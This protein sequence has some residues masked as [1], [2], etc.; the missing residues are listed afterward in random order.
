MIWYKKYF[1]K[2]EIS[3]LN[4]D[5]IQSQLLVKLKN[6]LNKLPNDIN[7][8]EDIENIN[9]EFKDSIGKQK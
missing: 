4:K 7:S 8:K 1:E 2:Q 6:I 3:S 9:K 5:K